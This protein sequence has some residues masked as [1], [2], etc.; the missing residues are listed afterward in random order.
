MKSPFTLAQT[1][2]GLRL[3]VQTTQKNLLEN[4]DTENTD[5][6]WHFNAALFNLILMR[7]RMWYQ[8]EVMLQIALGYNRSTGPRDWIVEN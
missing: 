1:E 5:F 6:P 8:W 7:G 3:S 4:K 2:I